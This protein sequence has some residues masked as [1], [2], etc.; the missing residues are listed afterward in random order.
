[1]GRGLHTAPAH[2]HSHLGG[3]GV[4]AVVSILKLGGVGGLLP[5]HWEASP[6]TLGQKKAWSDFKAI[7]AGGWP[8][9]FRLPHPCRGLSTFPT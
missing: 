7:R 4:G 6:G 9:A 3:G 8:H 1:M 2:E 5:P